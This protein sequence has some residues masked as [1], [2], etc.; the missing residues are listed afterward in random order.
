MLVLS[1]KIGEVVVVPRLKLTL[2]VLDI[3]EKCVRLGITA[4]ANI[5]LYRE[6]LWDRM[7]EVCK[8]AS[9]VPIAEMS[10]CPDAGPCLVAPAFD[11]ALDSVGGDRVSTT[12]AGPNCCLLEQTLAEL[13]CREHAPFLES[14]GSATEQEILAA[15]QKLGKDFP[16]SYRVFLREYGGGTFRQYHI[17]GICDEGD[18]S[19]IVLAN[20]RY[21]DSALPRLMKFARDFSGRE[22]FFDT[23]KPAS[24]GEYPVVVLGSEVVDCTIADSFLDFLCL[25]AFERKGRRDRKVDA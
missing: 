11:G 22:Y 3:N 23:T 25:A 21:S 2:R 1:R 16:R 8:R 18:S 15:E 4:P 20:R 14:F 24:N 6:E 19:D 9:Q 10:E 12:R 5:S 13:L 7:R 17:F